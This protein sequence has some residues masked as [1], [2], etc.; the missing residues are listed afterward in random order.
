MFGSAHRTAPAHAHHML[1]Y[2]CRWR[3]RRTD[4][5]HVGR[6]GVSSSRLYAMGSVCY[7]HIYLCSSEVLLCFGRRREDG[8]RLLART[9]LYILQYR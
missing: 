6:G 1:D 9:A 8:T 2:W 3:I 7:L 5:V 4:R